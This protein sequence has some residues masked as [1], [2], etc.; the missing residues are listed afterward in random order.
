M[1]KLSPEAR[2]IKI[3]KILR[4]A[5]QGMTPPAAVEIVQTYGKDP[6]LILISCLLSLRTRDTTSVAASH[7]LFKLAKTPEEMLKLPVPSIEKAIY[8]TGFYHRKAALLHTVSQDLIDRFDGKVPDS[9][10]KL[11]SIK[12]VGGKTAN[13]VLGVAFDIPAICVDTH[14]HRISNR[15]GI[16]NTKTIEQTEQALKKI[17]PKQYWVEWNHLLVVWGQNICVPISPLCSKC[18]IY[19]LCERKGVIKHR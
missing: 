5:T 13:L 11:Q 15:L 19:D 8:P 6:Y 18:A 7:R 14:V 1:D 2:A 12:G 17:I 3:I 10:Q 16:I 4:K 9:Y